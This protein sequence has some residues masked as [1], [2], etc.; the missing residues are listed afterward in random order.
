MLLSS[1]QPSIEVST[2]S[3]IECGTNRT[4]SRSVSWNHTG[5]YLAYASSD[6]TARLV[7]LDSSTSSAR[8]T[9][10]ISGHTGP[11]TKVRFHP[12]EVT[13]VLTAST[14]QTI[15]LWDLRQSTP[16]TVGMLEG[17]QTLSV[18]WGRDDSLSHYIVITERNGKVSVYDRRALYLNRPSS[19]NTSVAGTGRST[20]AVH[21]FDNLPLFVDCAI[22]SPN[23]GEYLVG[24]VT[25]HGEGMAD[26]GAW[27]WKSDDKDV[28]ME[29]APCLKF[30][31]PAHAG[32]IYSLD[33]SPDGK[34]LATGGSDALV[35]LW[36]TDCMICTHMFA[37]P[38]KLIRSVAFSHDGH[39][40][41]VGNEENDISLV[42][43]ATGL[44]VGSI[45]LA[46]RR[47][48][49]VEVAWHP[50]VPIV[51]CARTEQFMGDRPPPPPIAIA[52]LSIA[53]AQQ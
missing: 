44:S 17:K 25:S 26:I 11:V 40:L 16:N 1:G 52:K 8:E 39:I 47:G 41:A 35:G 48:G 43:A 14:D 30:L 18:E 51:A 21:V 38:T 20:V 23:G 36:D 6:R 10:V 32:P 12:K 13:M 15:R 24:G 33:L 53:P 46:Q 29:K 42:E 4:S 37:Q 34:R 28:D 5:F 2:T 19:A 49:A 22:F 31:Y 50:T 27:K 7:T 45:Q 9:H 3:L